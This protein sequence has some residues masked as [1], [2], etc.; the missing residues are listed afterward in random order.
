M[1]VNYANLQELGKKL[2]YE[3]YANFVVLIYRHIRV[4]MDNGA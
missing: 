3:D 4:P 2:F 1:Y